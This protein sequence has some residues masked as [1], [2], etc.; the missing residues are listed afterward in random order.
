MKREAGRIPLWVLALLP[1]VLVAL[2][3]DRLPGQV[4]LP[5][6][7][8]GTG[9]KA[10]LWLLAVLG[11]A[12]ALPPRL[13]LGK[14]RR[15]LETAA[16]ILLF[17]LG[18]VTAAL[19]ANLLQHDRLSWARMGSFCQPIRPSSYLLFRRGSLLRPMRRL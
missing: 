11:P 10:G 18:G 6:S 3:Y 14:L 5:W 8:P 19:T 13:G 17:V 4:S 16:L 9:G 2:C 12:L 1:L 15:R 7:G